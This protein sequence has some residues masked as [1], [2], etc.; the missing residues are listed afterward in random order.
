MVVKVR[1]YRAG[2]KRR[3]DSEKTG[4]FHSFAIVSPIPPLQNER[5]WKSPKKTVNRVGWATGV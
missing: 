1:R 5:Q 4:P 2:Y 3:T